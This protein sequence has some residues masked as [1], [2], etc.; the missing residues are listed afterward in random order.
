MIK[1]RTVR[2]GINKGDIA[3]T[4]SCSHGQCSF[5]E[6]EEQSSANHYQV[7]TTQCFLLGIKVFFNDIKKQNICEFLWMLMLTLA[8]P[9]TPPEPSL[10]LYV[11]YL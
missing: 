3:E 1:R 2:N 8:P 6:E 5:D 10:R 9:P 11:V 7:K 4:Q